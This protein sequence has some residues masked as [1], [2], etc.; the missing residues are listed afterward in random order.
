[1]LCTDNPA[2]SAGM[3]LARPHAGAIA[4]NSGLRNR[5]I[6]IN[7][8]PD[9]RRIVKTELE[10]EGFSVSDFSNGEA[11]L[12]RLEG[13]ADADIVVLDWSIEKT[14]SLDL[15][16]TLRE[17]GID[18][19][20]VSL[21]DRSTPIHERLALQLGAVDFID[22]S[23]GTEILAARLRLVVRNER[24]APKAD[25]TIQCRRLTLKP[26]AGRAYWDEND[27]NLTVSEFK[28]V[29]LIV[30]RAGEY[31]SYRQIYDAMH[32]VG[33]V[34]GVGEHGFRANVRSSIKRIRRKFLECD[35]TFDE[36]RNY[37]GFGY[38]WGV[39]PR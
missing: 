24:Q 34:A 37:N 6:F 15:L 25:Q 1:M 36:I 22:K 8:D 30:S 5:L 4:N 33:V 18:L 12:D 31:V 9:F 11:M 10:D 38:C 27:V 29:H 26:E 16:P 14:S 2:F 21:T 23:R 3:G 35:A 17:R 39:P 7:D 28:I 32:Y 13:G 19:P 20:V